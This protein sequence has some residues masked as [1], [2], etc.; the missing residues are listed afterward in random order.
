MR[1][2]A[3]ML[4]S[5]LMPM[6]VKKHREVF[7]V[8]GWFR[9]CFIFQHWAKPNQLHSQRAVGKEARRKNWP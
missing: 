8:A 3:Q 4:T 2:N 1:N 6:F 9:H 5:T 7:L